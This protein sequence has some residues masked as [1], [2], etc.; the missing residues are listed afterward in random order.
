MC[1]VL[2][3]FAPGDRYPLV[4]GAVRDEF[5]DRAWDPPAAHWGGH[6]L[7]GRD[8]T[9]GGTWLAVDPA[10]PAVAAVLNGL[11][12]PVRGTRPSRGGLPLAAL[13]GEVPA[14]PAGYDGF[15][16]VLGTPA[17]VT[18]WSWDGVALTVRHLAPGDHLIVNEGVDPDRPVV[19][20]LRAADGHDDWQR[21]LGDDV[22]LVDREYQGRRYGST[23]TSLVTLGADGVRYEFNPRPRDAGSWYRVPP[24]PSSP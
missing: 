20:K 22:V 12:L 6:V 5:V 14:R 15:H 23:S 4:F 19:E 18:V 10:A 1:T 13:R 24:L 11:R 3:R 2:L 21:L 9:A 7:G 17:A 16:L 8:R